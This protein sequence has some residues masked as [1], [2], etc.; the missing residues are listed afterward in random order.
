VASPSVVASLAKQETYAFSLGL[1]NS[2]AEAFL[3]FDLFVLLIQPEQSLQSVKKRVRVLGQLGGGSPG[4]GSW[5]VEELV[6]EPLESVGDIVFLALGELGMA[7][8]QRFLLAESD[9]IG[10]ISE[11]AE[12]IA[13]MGPV[14]EVGQTDLGLSLDD[15]QGRVDPLLTLLAVLVGLLPEVVDVVEH[16]VGEIADLRVEIAGDGDVED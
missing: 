5:V 13:G 10:V 15:R 8:Q 6:L 1:T 3:F 2:Q 12:D 4:G 14:A 7:G 11:L 16:D 9:G